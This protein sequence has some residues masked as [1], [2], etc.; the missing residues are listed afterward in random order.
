VPRPSHLVLAAIVGASACARAATPPLGN[1][2]LYVDTDATV[3][4]LVGELRVDLFRTDGT[5]YASRDISAPSPSS[6]P[7]SFGVSLAEGASDTQVVAR[8]RAYPSGKVQDYRGYSYQG[9]P[10]GPPLDNVPTPMP[11]SGPRL[12]DTRGD[13]VTPATEPEPGVAID[14]LVLVLLTQG[15]VEAVTVTLAGACFGTMADMRDFGSLQTCVDTEA[16][17]EPLVVASVTPGLPGPA[18]SVQGAFEAPYAQPCSG[19]PRTPSKG[20]GG[21][22]L[23]DDEICVVGGAFVFGTRDDAIED[24][25]DDWPERIAL[26]PSFYMDRYEYTVARYRTVLDKGTAEGYVSANDGA[27]SDDEDSPTFCTFSNVDEGRE[28]FPVNCLYQSAARAACQAGGGDLPLEVQWEYAASMSGR[29]A[30]TAYPWGDG[31]STY[32]LCRDVVYQRGT[33]LSTDICDGA[34]IGPASATAVD[35]DGG[36]WSVAL[37]IV[38]LSG[39]VS[40]LTRDTFAPLQ[41]NCWMSAPLLLP[42]CLPNKG[43]VITA[44][45][46]SWNLESDQIIVASRAALEIQGASTGVGFRCVRSAGGP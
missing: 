46:G 40:E 5:W 43:P 44:R 34:G 1:V 17:L 19:T 13:D 11:T 45:G 16:Q 23:H 26:V 18:Q 28:E 7:V 37:H 22:P 27:L 2:V 14:Q 38:D 29:P 35:F 9:R 24:P 39:S 6:W 4:K 21:V 41:A 36:D 8:L 20:P 30:K 42:S 32:P 15:S 31:T 12:L 25:T 3:P 33:T 10:T